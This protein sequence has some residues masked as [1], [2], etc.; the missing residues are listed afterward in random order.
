MLRFDRTSLTSQIR[1]TALFP[2]LFLPPT[3]AHVQ[4]NLKVS[5]RYDAILSIS[6]SLSCT[7]SI[8]E[9]PLLQYLVSGELQSLL[10]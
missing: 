4:Y 5:V 7:I 1:W 2:F 10:T 9:P 3:E 8:S 6:K